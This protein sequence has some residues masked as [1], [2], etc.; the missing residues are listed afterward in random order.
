[1]QLAITCALGL[2]SVVRKEVERLGLPVTS[3]VDRVVR[4]EGDWDALA[5]A[6]LWSRTG[7]R[8]WVELASGPAKT[9]D[10]AYALIASVPWKDWLPKDWPALVTATSLRSALAAES[11]LQAV[12][13]KATMAA[14]LAGGYGLVREDPNLPSLHVELLLVGDELRVLLDATGPDALHKRSYR[15]QAGEAPL[16]ESLA[17]GLVQLAGWSFKDPFFDPFCG[18]GTIA[19]EAALYAA[20]MAPGLT[21]SFAFEKWPATPAGLPEKAREKARAAAITDKTYAIFASD[22]DGFAVQMAE[23]AAKKA[24]VAHLIKFSIKPFVPADIAPAGALVCN[25]PYGVRMGAGQDLSP[26]YE[27]LV[28]LFEKNPGLHGGVLTAWEGADAAFAGW[29]GRK[30]RV[31]GVDARFWQRRRS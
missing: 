15:T 14:V 31:G 22:E 13:K 5:A 23:T 27:S 25:P 7:S 9:F 8:V 30:F 17:A 3:V 1:M 20:N 16:K 4:F 28:G 24:G 26:L 6:H 29:K 2:E 19:I 12:G 11:A 21:R 10:Q 18:S